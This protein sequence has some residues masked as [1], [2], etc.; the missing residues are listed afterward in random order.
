MNNTD[1]NNRK[2]VAALKVLVLTPH[3]NRY[4]STHDPKALEQAKQALRDSGHDVGDQ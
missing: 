1:G 4:L 2:I 3:I